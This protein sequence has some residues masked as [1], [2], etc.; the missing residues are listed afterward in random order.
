MSGVKVY[1]NEVVNV[2]VFQR[3]GG[4]LVYSNEVVVNICVL[5]G[6]A[7]VKVYSNEVVVNVSVLEWGRRQGIQ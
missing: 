3:W 4:C 7:D 5:E 2:C 6:G 1:S